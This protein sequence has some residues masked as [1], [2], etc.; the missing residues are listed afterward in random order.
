MVRVTTTS[1]WRTRDGSISCNWDFRQLQTLHKNVVT[2]VGCSSHR[3]H[4]QTI[5]FIQK[6]FLAKHFFWIIR[7][8]KFSHQMV[9]LQSSLKSKLVDQRANQ[10]LNSK[11][12]LG[13]SWCQLLTN[14]KNNLHHESLSSEF[15]EKPDENFTDHRNSLTKSIPNRIAFN[16]KFFFH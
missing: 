2:R 15:P 4:Y 13:Q 9:S 8:K 11:F 16:E 10:E 5:F 6:S 14:S 12:I 1:C 3:E 7:E